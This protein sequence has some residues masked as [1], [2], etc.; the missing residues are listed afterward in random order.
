MIDPAVLISADSIHV[1]T[2]MVRMGFVNVFD[3]GV[4]M[5]YTMFDQFRIQS[6]I[7]HR[8]LE[9][10]VLSRRVEATP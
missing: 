10:Y 3:G 6:M 1:Q 7:P 8:D 4:T 2:R 9:K 5:C